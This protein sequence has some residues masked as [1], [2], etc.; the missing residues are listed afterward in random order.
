MDYRASLTLLKLKT[1]SKFKIG[2][3]LEFEIKN[4]EKYNLL[5]TKTHSLGLLFFLGFTFV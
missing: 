2:L 5:K 3:I 1:E 4:K